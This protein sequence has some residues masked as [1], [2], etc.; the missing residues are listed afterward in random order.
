MKS[1]AA[2]TF[3]MTNMTL[4]SWVVGHMLFGFLV[5]GCRVLDIL[6]SGSIQDPACFG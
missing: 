5:V 6:G 4:I 3:N 2:V 1:N